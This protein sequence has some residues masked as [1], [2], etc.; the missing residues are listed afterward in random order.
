MLFS[1]VRMS[2]FLL[3]VALAAAY[4]P[5][6]RAATVT[7]D[8]S[9]IT[10][11]PEQA[12]VFF[13]NLPI[14]SI[15]H[16]MPL[17]P[18]VE[19]VDDTQYY[20]KY[21]VVY[22]SVNGQKVP[23]FLYVPKPAIKNYPDT[24]PAE[25]KATF[26]KRVNTLQGPP[27]PAM[28]FMHF[29]QSDKSLADAFAPQFVLYGYVVFSIDGVFKGERA[30]PGR[31]IL[32]FNPK[33]TVD[34][35]RQQ[36]MDIIRG[37]DYM[38][39]RPDIIDMNRLGYF[40]VS[41]GAITGTIATAVDQRYKAVVL[42]DGAADLSMIYKKSDL[43]DIKEAVEKIKATGYTLEQ[44]FDML[45]AVD[46]LYYAPHI[47]PRPALLINGKFD[48]LYPREAMV[49]FHRVVQE[50]KEVRWFDSGHILPINNVIMLTL[51][52]FG[53]YLK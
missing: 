17:N 42:A 11:T 45:R 51:K 25:Q 18:K 47:S 21:H 6:A 9:T 44:A 27:W 50:P 3:M 38:A 26:M 24:L 8:E 36:V 48:E 52:W 1:K 29:L 53:H 32:E 39:S 15:D 30:Q 2:I 49:Q 19:Q 20:T 23:A 46:P 43:P 31:N 16:S 5:A 4:T 22:D 7:D 12:K 13:D 34:N 14:L 35:I 37:T 41:M 33:D 10:Q 40:G 28:F